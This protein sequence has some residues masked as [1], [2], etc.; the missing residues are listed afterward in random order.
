MSAPEIEKVAP[1]RIPE[2]ATVVK[3]LAAVEDWKK[4]HPEAWAELAAIAKVLNPSLKAA[5]EV[6]KVRRVS[7]G[8]FDLFK[9]QPSFD[10][11]A[12]YAAVGRQRFASMGGTF[13]PE[14]PVVDRTKFVALMATEKV[15]AELEESVVTW[16]PYFHKPEP[17]S[18]P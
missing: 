14:T 9:F 7:S 5:G 6:V 11:P 2:V 12:L 1:S 3:Q 16:T 10:G 4:R 8:P 13:E 18:I 15:N 17:I